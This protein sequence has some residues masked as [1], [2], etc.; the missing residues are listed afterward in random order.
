M[1]SGKRM[2]SE[3]LGDVSSL[4]GHIVHLGCGSYRKKKEKGNFSDIATGIMGI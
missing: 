2:Q 1:K 4:K 3:T